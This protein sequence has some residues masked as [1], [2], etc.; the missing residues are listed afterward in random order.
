MSNNEIFRDLG[1]RR[2][3]FTRL[4]GESAYDF[5]A[6]RAMERQVRHMT[7]AGRVVWIGPMGPRRNKNL[8]A[9]RFNRE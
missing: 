6:R 7:I 2:R 4:E 5:C 8:G 3:S 9:A 1:F